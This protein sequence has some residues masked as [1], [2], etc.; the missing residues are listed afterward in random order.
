[1]DGSDVSITLNDNEINLPSL[2]INPSKKDTEQEGFLGKIHCY[3]MLCSNRE[4]H[5]LA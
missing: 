1:M 4:K 5:G 2:V 3:F